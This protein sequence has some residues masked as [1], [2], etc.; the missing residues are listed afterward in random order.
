MSLNQVIKSIRRNKSFLITTHTSL[1]G[2]ALGSALAFWALVKSL[3][4]QGTVVI[5][6][7]IPYGYEFMPFVARVKKPAS[8]CR[9]SAYDCFAILDCSGL[10]RCG[11]VAGLL[12]PRACILNIDHHVSNE[13]FGRANWIDAG[14]SSAAEMVY[15]LYKEMKVPFTKETATLLYAGILTDTGSFHYTNTSWKTHMAAADLLKH[16][17]AAPAMYQSIYENIPFSDMQ[18]LSLILPGIRRDASGKVAWFVI[19]ARVL[20]GRKVYFDLSERLLSFA[21]A[22]KG[23]EVAVLLRQNLRNKKEIRVNFRSQG[24]VNVNAIAK[25]FGGGGHRTASGATIRGGIT[26]A[27][28]R[29]IRVIRKNLPK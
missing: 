24:H 29:V 19:P 6:D 3:G 11:R 12:D 18:L 22:I 16:G 21:R 13:K 17:V 20:E 9:P 10:S 4:K 2:D 27:A 15:R 23:V 26:N 25:V 5:D 28:R 8:S 1:E 7:T 14:A